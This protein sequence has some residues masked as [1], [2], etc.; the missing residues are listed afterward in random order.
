MYLDIDDTG[1]EFKIRNYNP[2]HNESNWDDLWCNITVIIKNK[3]FRYVKSC[4]ELLLSCEIDKIK[5]NLKALLDDKIK[6]EEEINFIEPDL[7]M[8]LH[9]KRNCKENPKLV[10][11]RE[12]YEIIDI[13][14]EFIL[15]LTDNE[16]AYTGQKYI[17]P[18]NREEIQQLYEYLLSSDIEE[19]LDD[20]EWDDEEYFDNFDYIIE[21]V[22]VPLDEAEELFYPAIMERGEVYFEEGR[23]NNLQKIK[24]T[25]LAQVEGNDLNEYGVVIR[26]DDNSNILDMRCTCPCDFD[27]KHQYATIL[28]IRKKKK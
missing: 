21:R 16:R 23:V 6:Q 11:I 10:Y 7:S 8:I 3:Y 13:R 2:N 14:M 24:D 28:E 26:V 17:I 27:C 19:N 22:D 20:M 9:P 15:N 18:F 1:F 25:Y 12:G 4:D 5:K